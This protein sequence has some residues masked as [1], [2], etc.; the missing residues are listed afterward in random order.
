[1]LVFVR[2]SLV[3]GAFNG[4]QFALCAFTAGQAYVLCGGPVGHLA[5]SDFPRVLF[6]VLVA[7]LVH[8]AVNALLMMGVV[9]LAEKASPRQVLLGTLLKSLPGYLGYGIFGLLMAVLWVGVDIGVLSGLLVLL[10]L[11]VAP[12]GLLAVRRRAAGVRVDDPRARA[13]GRDQGP[14]HPRAQRA[15][16]AG[17]R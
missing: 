1:M 12:L 14:L 11:V 16:V 3:K 9:S 2:Y 6:P 4:A 7:D 17:P 10:P 15:G 13:G 5:A 8:C